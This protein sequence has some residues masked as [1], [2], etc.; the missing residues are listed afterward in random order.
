[1][2]TVSTQIQ[3]QQKSYLPRAVSQLHWMFRI[4]VV[5]WIRERYFE[6]LTLLHR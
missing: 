5:F 3:Q 1:L 4:D 2:H 6:K